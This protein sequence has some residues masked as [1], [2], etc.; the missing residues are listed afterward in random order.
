MRHCGCKARIQFQVHG[1]T[2]KSRTRAVR[3][4]HLRLKGL[5]EMK[6]IML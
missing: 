3:G 5:A 6:D 1:F 2:N 4:P